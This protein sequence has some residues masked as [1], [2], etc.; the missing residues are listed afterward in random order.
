MG[1]SRFTLPGRDYH[2]PEVFALERERIFFRHWFY[3]GRVDSL[4][5]PGDFL[6]ADVVGESI[7]IVRG[8]DGELR[9][10]LQRLPPSRLAAVRGGVVRAAAR[11]RQVPVPRLELLVRRPADRHAVHGQGRDRPRGVRAL[12]RHGRGL[13]GLRLRPPRRAGRE[14]AGQP[15]RAG[16]RL[17][18]S[19]TSASASASC[20]PPT[21]R[22]ARSPRTGRSRS[23]TTTSACTARRCTR[24]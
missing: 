18:S 16:R 10:L 9:A 21:R 24:S 15:A 19:S 1:G 22:S 17:A 14:P 4:A 11:R 5:E 12:A 20:A 6:A 13:G 23:R 8:K 3:A 7:L 2:A